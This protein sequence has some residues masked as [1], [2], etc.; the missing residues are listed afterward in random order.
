MAFKTSSNMSYAISLLCIVVGLLGLNFYDWPPNRDIT[1][2]GTMAQELINGK[3]LYVDVWDIKPPAIFITYMIAQW[4]VSSKPLQILLLDLLPTV[5]VLVALIKS[6]R[7]AGFGNAAGVWSGLFWVVLS[8]DLRLQMHEPNTEVFIN[9]CVMLAFLQF[10]R[11]KRGSPTLAPAMIGVLFAVACLFKTV[12]IAM[13]IVIGLTYLVLPPPGCRRSTATGQVA[14]MA[15]SGAI[16]I[17][18]VLGYF[19][20]TERFQVFWEAM[21]GAGVNYAGDIWQNVLDGL[22]LSPIVGDRT[23][24]RVAVA[25]VPWLSVALLA[26]FDRERRRSWVL[27]GA[28]AFSAL[29]AVG[30]PGNFYAHYFQLLVPP[31]CLGLGWLTALFAGQS[32]SI[33]TT[34]TPALLGLCLAVLFAYEARTYRMPAEMLL[35]GT[36][37]ELYLETQKLGR[38]LNDVLQDD[39]I[40]YQW[41]EESGL[42]WYSGK[43]PRASVLRF[44]LFSGPQAE[45]LTDQTQQSLMAQPP[46]LI[47]AV[48]RIL[49]NSEGH[50]VFEWIRSH[51]VPLQPEE[52]GERKFFT[53]FVPADAS[54]ELVWRVVGVRDTASAAE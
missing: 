50:P 17:A 22:T 33:L 41:G 8:G 53:F 29:V 30:L 24:L 46:D 21:V 49:D 35:R 6:G 43:R 18:A 23:L 48:N 14:V 12:A 39:E 26:W 52:P 34:A 19:A 44:P 45:R 51:Y 13:A 5:V 54:P 32:R 36:Y 40:L 31:L 10:L 16:C 1:T 15:T 27:L 28:Y 2:Y 42:Y 9:A 20:V 4:L 37:Q 7:E 11:L 3:A 38:R 25:I 47:V